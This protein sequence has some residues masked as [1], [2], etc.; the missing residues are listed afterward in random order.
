MFHGVFTKKYGFVAANR[1]WMVCEILGD[2]YF[3]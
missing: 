2:A 1:N 3:T